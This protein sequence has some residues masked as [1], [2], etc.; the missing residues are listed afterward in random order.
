ML[1]SDEYNQKLA[2]LQ[3]ELEEL[4]ASLPA[5]SLPASLLIR[6]EDL[7]AEIATLQTQLDDTSPDS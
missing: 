3:C 6:I 5:H 1:S 7:E 4:T 2:E